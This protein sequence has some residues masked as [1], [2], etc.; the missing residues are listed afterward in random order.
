MPRIITRI[1]FALLICALPSLGSAAE[2]A[3]QAAEAKP[4]APIPTEAPT[5]A[6]LPAATTEAPKPQQLRI[7]YIDIVRISTESSL[8]KA[9]AAQAK[10]KQGKLQAQITEKRK[11]LDRQKKA[12]ETQF[13][14]LS[15]AQRDAK[16]KE[17][18]KKVESFQKF[19][20]NAEKEM[21]TLQQGLGKSFNE[22]VQQAA[23]E[24]GTA[25]SLALV[26]LK[27]EILYQAGSVETRDVSEGVIKL[28]NEKWVKK[29]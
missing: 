10:Q 3:P 4:A 12:L 14:S 13:A 28:M 2:Q 18:Q 1:L 9:S 6:P 21:Q 27:R 15:P 5:P 24:Y 29:K 17:F 25:N 19:G 23:T 16:A 8:G 22:A 7:G 20:M 26:I 11:Q